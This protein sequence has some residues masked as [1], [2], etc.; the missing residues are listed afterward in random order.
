MKQDFRD[1]VFSVVH[2]LMRADPYIVIL[3]ND[4]H[5]WGLDAI[6]KEFPER[7]INMGVAEQ[8]MMSVAGGLASCGKYVF[9]YGQSAHL[10]RGWEQIKVSICLANLPVTILSLGGPSMWRDGPTHFGDE[11][12]ACMRTLSNM[13]VCGPLQLGDDVDGVVK[14]AYHAKTPHY[15]RFDKHMPPDE[16]IPV[17]G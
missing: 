6:R 5:A 10:M 1:A 9:V 7:A 12:L 17:N 13:R 16:G 8:N 4:N 14:A 15:I 3:S 11:D 2:D